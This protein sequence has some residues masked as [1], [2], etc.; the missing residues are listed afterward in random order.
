MK[1]TES[2]LSLRLA[3]EINKGLIKKMGKT[4][5]ANSF[6]NQFNLR[7]YGTTTI[8]RETARKWRLGLAVPSMDKLAVLI[9]WLDIDVLNLFDLPS[10][11]PRDHVGLLNE[12]NPLKRPLS[13][14]LDAKTTRK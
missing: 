5:S 4:P 7:A 8:T 2:S 13:S 3:F 12:A 1:S 11:L 9:E 10:R 14:D 6:A